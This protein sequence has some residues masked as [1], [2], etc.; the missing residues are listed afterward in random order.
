M[1]RQASVKG[2]QRQPS[3]A[4]RVSGYEANQSQSSHI[5]SQPSQ[6]RQSVPSEQ[7]RSSAQYKNPPMQV[8]DNDEDAFGT[9]DAAF[10]L[11]SSLFF[12]SLFLY[13]YIISRNHMHKPVSKYL[14]QMIAHWFFFPAG[15]KVVD[16]PSCGWPDNSDEEE[17]N[18]VLIFLLT[19]SRTILHFRPFLK[20]KWVTNN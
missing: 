12:T 3:L 6:S 7:R 8:E 14:L 2:Q 15:N 20:D 16:G 5:R 10:G 13:A 11:V 17:S 18:K 4:G 1:E 9:G 19:V